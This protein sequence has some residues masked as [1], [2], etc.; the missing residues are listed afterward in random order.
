MYS[1]VGIVWAIAAIYEVVSGGDP[2]WAQVYVLASV[3]CSVGAGIMRAIKE[4]GG[5]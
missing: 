1:I 3:I 5:K 4:A 2:G